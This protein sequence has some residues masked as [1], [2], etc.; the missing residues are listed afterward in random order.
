MKE[1]I[2]KCYLEIEETDKMIY[3]LNQEIAKVRTQLSEC[4]NELES[5]RETRNRLQ[6]ELD[7]IDTRLDRGSGIDRIKARKDQLKDLEKELD[8][9]KQQLIYNE[10]E[11]RK[12]S[13]DK[14]EAHEFYTTAEKELL[15]CEENTQNACEIYERKVYKISQFDFAKADL[16][17]Q[18]EW[19]KGQL[20]DLMQKLSQINDEIANFKSEAMKIQGQRLI[21]KED[22]STLTSDHQALVNE[23]ETAERLRVEGI[24]PSLLMNYSK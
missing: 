22:L 23:I 18:I 13:E 2:Q 7:S 16:L 10:E 20:K 6:N 3:D 21:V 14:F 5:S 9:Y 8:D 24:L 19:N 12:H 17:N 4:Q 1:D 15:V 11:L